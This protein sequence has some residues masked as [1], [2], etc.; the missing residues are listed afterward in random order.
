MCAVSPLMFFL[1][2]PSCLE[3][4]VTDV[5]LSGGLWPFPQGWGG[6]HSLAAVG[7]SPM[8]VYCVLYLGPSSP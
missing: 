6:M 5:P 4:S 2:A 3:L 8:H 1:V 7:F